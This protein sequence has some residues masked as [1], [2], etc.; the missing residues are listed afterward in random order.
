MGIG[1]PVIVTE[2]PET[3][4]IPEAGCLRVPPGVDEEAVLLDQM[5]LIA[6]FPEIR[7]RVGARGAAHIRGHHSLGNAVMGYWQVIDSIVRMTAGLTC[8][9]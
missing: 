2:G 4:E 1:K 7:R 8:T 5:A 3:A 6:G 9:P